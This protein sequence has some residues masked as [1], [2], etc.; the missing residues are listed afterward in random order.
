MSECRC[1]A[2]A[3]RH[4]RVGLCKRAFKRV[5]RTPSAMAIFRLAIK[6]TTVSNILLFQAQ[7]DFI[8]VQESVR[9]VD[10]EALKRSSG[11]SYRC[12]CR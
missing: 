2:P 11:T 9:V 6:T 12:I 5:D 1:R 7:F 3:L 10:Y 8:T 4:N